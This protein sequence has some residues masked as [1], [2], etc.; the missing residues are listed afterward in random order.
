MRS[1]PALDFGRLIAGS[2]PCFGFALLA[3]APPEAKKDGS[4]QER[5]HHQKNQNSH[6]RFLYWLRERAG[7]KCCLVRE[8]WLRACGFART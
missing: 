3:L 6:M 5:G 4:D 1:G 8:D 7:G 2:C